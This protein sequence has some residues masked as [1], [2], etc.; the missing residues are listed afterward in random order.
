MSLKAIVNSLDGLS[1]DI[2]KEYKQ[3]GDK[4]YLD[5]TETE[6]YALED[7]RSL[8]SALSSEREAAREAKDK[9]K[10]LGDIDVDAA[11]EALRKVKEY[12]DSPPEK[13]FE[14]Q[15]KLRED[16]LTTKHKKEV[17]Q[18]DNTLKE[19]T[20]QLE[21]Q[22]ITASATQ[23]IASKKGSVELLLPIVSKMTRIRRVDGNKAI[24]EVLDEKNQPR[25]SSKQGS[26][27]AMSIAELV[28]EMSQKEVYA[29][30]F[31]SSGVTGIGAETGKPTKGIGKDHVISAG[32]ARDIR[33]YRAAK[34]AA[35]KAG[36]SLEISS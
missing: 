36:V 22:L 25:I 9:L 15:F 10:T 35:A 6:G 1:E 11:K 20:N 23:A 4:Y 12:Q 18:K 21:E 24:V 29:R 26:T 19:L 31:D 5:V 34:E 32:D 27:E 33:K 16:Q 7:V 8:K 3:K 28:D 2:K 30:A 14:E 13:K 17:E